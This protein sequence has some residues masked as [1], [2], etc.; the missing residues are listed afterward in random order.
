MTVQE[1]SDDADVW[2]FVDLESDH[3]DALRA[4]P[5]V[6]VAFSRSG[7]WLSLSGTVEFVTGKK[8]EGTSGTTEL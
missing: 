8:P 4:N 3:A 1:V 5:A 7:S 2:L 6:N